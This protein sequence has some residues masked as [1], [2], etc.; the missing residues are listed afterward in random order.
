MERRPPSVAKSS[1]TALEAHDN[2]NRL[3]E[4]Q[5]VIRRRSGWRE[6]YLGR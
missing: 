5:G 6:T 1:F 2:Q 3:V 4:E